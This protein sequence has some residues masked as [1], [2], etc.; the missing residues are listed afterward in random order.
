MRKIITISAAL[1]IAC[2]PAFSQQDFKRHYLSASRG[3]NYSL[4]KSN[5][6]YIHNSDVILPDVNNSQ[7]NI[8]YA[9]FIYPHYGIGVNLQVNTGSNSVF[10]L[11]KDFYIEYIRYDYTHVISFLGG[12]F[13]CRWYPGQSEFGYRNLNIRQ[14]GKWHDVT[15]RWMLQASVGAGYMLD[16]MTD[17]T[18]ESFLNLANEGKPYHGVIVYGGSR[19]GGVGYIASAGAHYRFA[20]FVGIGFTVNGL[21]GRVLLKEHINKD[22]RTISSTI[23][24]L[25]WSAG[26]EFY[27]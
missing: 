8:D 4:V 6:R 26:L 19:G 27:L 22:I 14:S 25:G 15:S 2:Q 11:E 1:I 7:W 21:F 5:V 20:S 24:R 18:K 23:S 17:L 9:Y 10:Q 13:L 16:D 12:F 3:I